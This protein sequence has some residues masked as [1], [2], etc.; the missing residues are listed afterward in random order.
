MKLSSGEKAVLAMELINIMLVL[1]FLY[2]FDFLSILAV[3]SLLFV[4]CLFGFGGMSIGRGIR[5][6]FQQSRRP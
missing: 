3:I 6:L 1:G 2:V 4:W 5:S